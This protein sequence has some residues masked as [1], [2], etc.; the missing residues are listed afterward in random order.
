MLAAGPYDPGEGEYT[1]N[2]APLFAAGGYALT[3]GAPKKTDA[4]G[5][6]MMMYVESRGKM[7][8]DWSAPSFQRLF[9]SRALRVQVVFSPQGVWT[10]PKKGGGKQ[11]G[12][13]AKIDAI[14]VTIGRTGE[15]VALWMPGR[16]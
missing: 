4:N 16:K 7:P 10:L 9:Q 15:T 14:L 13:R 2:I 1:V 12:V 5:N 6:P 8:P 11:Y 3:H